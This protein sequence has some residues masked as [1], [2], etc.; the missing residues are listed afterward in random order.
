MTKCLLFTFIFTLTLSACLGSSIFILPCFLILIACS[1][2]TGIPIVAGFWVVL[3]RAWPGSSV[4]SGSGTSIS[5]EIGGLNEI[6]F[7]VEISS[8]CS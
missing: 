4:G 1:H 3:I 6:V 2:L 7:S 5:G 8:S